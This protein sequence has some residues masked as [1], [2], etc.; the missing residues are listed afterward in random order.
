MRNEPEGGSAFAK[1]DAPFLLGVESN[2]E[3]PADDEANIAWT[4]G[5]ID[6]ASDLSPGGTYLNFPGFVEEGEQLL[7]DTYGPNFD[8]LRDVK[9]KYDPDNVFRNNLNNPVKG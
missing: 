4:R 9:A 2:W 6:E 3:D 1:R 8:R 5:I 7:R